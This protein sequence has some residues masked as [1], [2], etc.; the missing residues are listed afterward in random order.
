M[1]GPKE[2]LKRG[3]FRDPEGLPENAMLVGFGLLMVA[4]AVYAHTAAG[5][6]SVLLALVAIQFLL[7]GVA[8]T[9]PGARERAVLRMT[10]LVLV[11]VIVALLVAVPDAV[12]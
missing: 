10:A 9:L 5:G 11:G 8:E 2:R 4:L 6:G 3:L 1:D 12:L 7:T